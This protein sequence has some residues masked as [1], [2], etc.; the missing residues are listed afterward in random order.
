MPS[1]AVMIDL[2][3]MGTTP[4][5]AIISIGAVRFN[6]EEYN[7]DDTFYR[8]VNLKSSQR[9]GGK[10]DGETIMWWMQQP[11]IARKVLYGDDSVLIE[12]AL[13]EFSAWVREKSLD[14]IW[15]NGAAFDNVMLAT[16]YRKLGWTAPWSYKMDRCY[17]TMVA[18]NPDIPRGYV[19][20]HH[21]MEDAVN[22]AAHLWKIVNREK[23]DESN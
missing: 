10:I 9:A 16:A 17:R 7:F 2:E 11:D 22:Q 14:E 19:N 15:G 23:K 12:T 1:N 6:Y 21:A 4:D 3:S 8:T 20:N 13:K 18:M 5:S